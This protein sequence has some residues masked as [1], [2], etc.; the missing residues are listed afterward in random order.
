[1]NIDECFGEGLLIKDTPSLEKARKSLENA[2]AHI[3]EANDN[4]KVGNYNL[5]IVCCYT[6]MFHTGR[7]LL[8]K[9]GVKERS[10]VCLIEYL[11]NGYPELVDSL[12]MM[13][14]YRRSRHAAIYALEYRITEFDASEAIKDA[15]EFLSKIEEMLD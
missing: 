15:E 8:F 2:R 14:S 12:V 6:S 10:H 7:S 1:M 5:V 11:K 3:K 13:D 4:L 9:E